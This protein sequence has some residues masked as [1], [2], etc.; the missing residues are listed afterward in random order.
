MKSDD[1]VRQG[2]KNDFEHYL[3]KVEAHLET[4][5]GLITIWKE[6]QKLQDLKSVEIAVNK[7]E[8]FY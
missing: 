8:V 3:S 6:E 5:I 7:D 1:E 2:G 4:E